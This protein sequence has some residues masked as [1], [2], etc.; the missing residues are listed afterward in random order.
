MTFFYNLMIGFVGVCS[1][2]SVAMGFSWV[3]ARLFSF[4]TNLGL[5]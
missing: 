3:V 2:L 4:I 5:I 1:V